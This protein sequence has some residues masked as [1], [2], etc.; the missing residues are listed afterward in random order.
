M[1]LISYKIIFVNLLTSTT[2]K[3]YLILPIHMSKSFDKYHP[4]SVFNYESEANQ[5]LNRPDAIV[6]DK[7]HTILTNL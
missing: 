6:H 2:I 5:S 7:L 3:F 4:S 1:S